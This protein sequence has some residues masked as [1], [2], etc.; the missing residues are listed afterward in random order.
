MD[1]QNVCYVYKQDQLIAT[2]SIHMHMDFTQNTITRW[3]DCDQ[4]G[5]SSVY[6]FSLTTV[7]Q[8]SNNRNPCPEGLIYICEHD[9]LRIPGNSIDQGSEMVIIGNNWQT[10]QC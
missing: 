5:N 10:N 2:T 9:S 4:C 8:T 1:I 6:V 3:L 7:I